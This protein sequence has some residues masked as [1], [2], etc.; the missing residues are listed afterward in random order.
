[1]HDTYQIE[2]RWSFFNK[3]EH[4]LLEKRKVCVFNMYRKHF[5]RC[6]LKAVV[7]DFLP[8]PVLSD[9][10]FFTDVPKVHSN[11]YPPT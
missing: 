1:M 3:S 10:F 7:L 2:V 9:T 6:R 5:L 4:S 11:L 8:F